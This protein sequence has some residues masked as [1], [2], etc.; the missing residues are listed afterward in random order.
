MWLKFDGIVVAVECRNVL[1]EAAEQDEQVSIEKDL[2]K[3]EQRVLDRWKKL[4]R[5][6]VIM[7]RVKK[8]YNFA[9]ES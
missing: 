9:Q 1:V 2:K 6:L 8:T 3:R 7:E 5:G 4:C